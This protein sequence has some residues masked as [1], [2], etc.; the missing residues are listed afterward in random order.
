MKGSRNRIAAVIRK[1]FRH[2]GRDRVS[3]L[4]LILMPLFILLMFG[5][6]LSFEVRHLNVQVCDL[7]VN[8]DTDSLFAQLDAEPKLQVVG[9][10][11]DTV[12][13]DRAFLR[14]DTRAV[15]AD[16]EVIEVWLDGSS[17]LLPMQERALIRPVIG[18]YLTGGSFPDMPEITFRY[19]PCMDSVYTTIPGV[20]LI[21]ILLVSSIILGISVNKEKEQGTFQYLRMTRLSGEE[22]I[23]GKLLPYF[24][25][26]LV[27]VAVV[28]AICRYF[29]IVIQGSLPLFYSLCILFTLCC[30]SLGLLV[31]AWFDRPIH[32]MLF[33]WCFLFIPNVFLSGF[34]FPTG[35]ADA[36][37]GK[38][39]S[40]L[41]GTAFLEAFRGIAYKGT[42]LLENSRWLL[43]LAGEWLGA[44]FLSVIGFRRRILP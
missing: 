28:Y 16:G 10:L 41:P 34:I 26:S 22:L 5:Y 2:I 1:E 33:C 32:V 23:L 9:R 21:V 27:H 44:S 29:G 30:M 38:L 43:L 14:D 12:A 24:L 42:G 19:N 35:P 7:G 20:A 36:G 3:G 25:I 39:L 18:R 6:A 31:S 8:P 15:V 40:L 11:T 4:F 37:F 13:V 17:P